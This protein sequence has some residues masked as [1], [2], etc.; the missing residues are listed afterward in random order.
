MLS[1]DVGLIVW[2]VV[3]VI[4]WV[5]SVLII[6]KASRAKDSRL[7]LFGA[8]SFCVPLLMTVPYFVFSKK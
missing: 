1:P 2:Q 3:F 6:L 4:S 5:L 8:I 7:L